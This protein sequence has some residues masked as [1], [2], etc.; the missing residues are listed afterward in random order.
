MHILQAA[1]LVPSTDSF[2]SDRLQALARWNRIHTIVVVLLFFG[3][4]GSLASWLGTAFPQLGGI[5]TVA[6]GAIGAIGTYTGILTVVYLFLGRLLS[7]LEAD[8][9]MLL[10]LRRKSN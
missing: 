1:G 7:Q 8:I 6:G 3:L 4:L 10:L 9:L 5:W 2:V